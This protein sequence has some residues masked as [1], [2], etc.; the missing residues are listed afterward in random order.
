MRKES[1]FIRPPTATDRSA[2]F[3]Q[4]VSRPLIIGRTDIK[5]AVQWAGRH[6][7]GFSH[8][9][10][11]MG[12]SALEKSWRGESAAPLIVYVCPIRQYRHVG[13]AV[14]MKGKAYGRP[15]G[16]PP[17]LHTKRGCFKI[18]FAIEQ[19]ENG[20]PRNKLRYVHGAD[21]LLPIYVLLSYML[22]NPATAGTRPATASPR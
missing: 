1:S 5:A 13:S 18:P 4:S 20:R 21:I 2:I 22:R 11:L 14:R 3:S 7:G 8:Q 17:P 12:L 6:A 19:R 15:A 9:R 10:E 16:P